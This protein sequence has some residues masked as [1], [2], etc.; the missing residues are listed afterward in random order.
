MRIRTVYSNLVLLLA[1]LVPTALIKAADPIGNPKKQFEQLR[2]LS[3]K[4]DRFGNAYYDLHG[5]AHQSLQTLM[6][7]RFAATDSICTELDSESAMDLPRY[8]AALFHVLAEVKDPASIPW[9]ERQ[10]Q[11]SRK[12]DVVQYW[13]P[14]WKTYL[15]G[16]SVGE[17]KWLTEPAKWSQFFYHWWQRETNADDR[18]SILRAMLGWL[19]DPGT[20]ARFRE[21]E[22]SSR[23]SD[24]EI[25]LAQLYLHQHTTVFSTNRLKE[26]IDRL[27]TAQDKE[28]FL[29]GCADEFRHEAFVPWLIQVVEQFPKEESGNAQWVLEAITFRRDVVGHEAWQHWISRHREEGRQKW[30][31]DAIAEL[32][33]LANTN[34]AAAV[35]FMERAMYRWKDIALLSDM[36][37]LANYKSLH[38]EIIGWINLTYQYRHQQFRSRLQSLALKIVNESENDLEDWAKRLTKAW[39]FLYEQKMSW[40]QYVR[41][42]NMKM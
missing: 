18:V 42:T 1:C 24:E 41:L 16:A 7:A 14:H 27:G 37:Q 6:I 36:E 12:D 5:N 29:L 3:Q 13:L 4:S 20:L 26:T 11:G 40:E 38:N 28:D 10:L 25:L 22:Q 32:K 19:H 2:K 17:V 23:S 30:K 31:E 35:R 9:L 21:I 8:R 34:S 15:R 39:D 33:T